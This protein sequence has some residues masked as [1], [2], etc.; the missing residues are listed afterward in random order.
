[1]GLDKIRQQRSIYGEAIAFFLLKDT[2][3]TVIKGIERFVVTLK[4]IR[5][6]SS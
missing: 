1:M 6:D 3:A 5:R 2:D 4:R